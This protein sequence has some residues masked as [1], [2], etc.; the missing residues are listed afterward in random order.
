[1]IYLNDDG[2]EGS[3]V[4]RCEV[5]DASGMTI[6]VREVWHD[7]MYFGTFC[8][9]CELRRQAT[10][11]VRAGAKVDPKAA[12]RRRIEWGPMRGLFKR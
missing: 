9:R 5:C 4:R 2:R 7:G 1:M 6:E 10:P 11:V 8:G 3:L 12:A